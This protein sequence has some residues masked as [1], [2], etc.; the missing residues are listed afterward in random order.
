MQVFYLYST[1]VSMT[2]GHVTIG[3]RGS[4]FFSQ[5]SWNGGDGLNLELLPPREGYWKIKY[6]KRFDRHNG[7][8]VTYIH[9]KEWV[10]PKPRVRRT[11]DRSPWHEYS[12]TDVTEEAVLQGQ[13]SCLGYLYYA[14]DQNAYLSELEL[15]TL[16][17]KL[18]NELRGHQFSMST[19]A[20]QPILTANMLTSSVKRIAG[21]IM[22]V[23]TGNI[24]L[25]LRRLGVTDVGRV[26]NPSASG[27]SLRNSALPDKEVARI[28]LE[29][30]YGWKPLLQD[31][32][33]GAEACAY[34]LNVAV[35]RA[36]KAEMIHKQK[37][38]RRSFDYN[39]GFCRTYGEAYHTRHIRVRYT[40]LP[41][42]NSLGLTD[43]S[44][45]I[46]ENIPFSFIADWFIP[47]GT[48]LENRYV[49]SCLRDDSLWTDF[50]KCKM[51]VEP[52]PWPG[53]PYAGTKATSSYASL[54]RVVYRDGSFPIRSPE[55]HFPK[56][57]IT[58][59][60]NSVA[61]LRVALR[62]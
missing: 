48:F 21:S 32:H 10:P 59:F 51:T 58:H 57:S 28:W 37:T 62:G 24:P 56:Q 53:N 60:L 31:V 36:R 8:V 49:L 44:S 55:F 29:M 5:K 61:L 1:G 25:A 17:N 39:D 22:A 15:S 19:A 18:V 20:A 33:D 41:A 6:A 50:H 52:L 14:G 27:R 9:S 45:L 38:A 54:N 46:W 11:R 43:P 35:E 13:Q 12:M 34:L 26:S 7:F 4:P 47:I 42:P 3:T 40:D 30:Q 23:R 2:F 16:T